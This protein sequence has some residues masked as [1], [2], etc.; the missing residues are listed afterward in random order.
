MISPKPR[1]SVSRSRFRPCVELLETRLAP[2]VDVLTYHNDNARDGLNNQ[3]TALTTANVNSTSFGRLYNVSVDGYVYAQ[4]LVMTNVS[5]PGQGTHNL[6]FIA[7]QHDSLY[8]FD[9]DQPS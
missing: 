6:V 8:A 9:G 3:E 7:T 2:S 4:P 1:R 5:V